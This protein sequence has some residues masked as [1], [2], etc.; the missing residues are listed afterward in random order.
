ME[1]KKKIN[2]KIIIPI[3]VIAIVVVAVIGI[4]VFRNIKETDT[5][6]YK[7]GDTVSTDITEF[8]LNDSQLTIVLSSII[9]ENYGLP[10]EYDARNDTNNI[11]VA[12]T[13]HTLAYM[14][15]TISNIGRGGELNV[16]GS[17][18]SVKY[19]NKFYVGKSNY[20]TRGLIAEKL[21][22]ATGYNK[23]ASNKWERMT[24]VNS[25]LFPNEKA[26]FRYCIDIDKEITNL[27]D[28]YYITFNLP[29][30]EGKTTPF[31]YVIND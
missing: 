12:N 5:R 30:S 15:F 10:K 7:I 21:E 19:D 29:N 25:L 23:V 28:K 1:E 17:I 6:Y 16:N 24:A 22:V 20:P 31:T 14:D 2:F 8:T 11:F 26:S 27:K 9:N 4:V 18:G 3:I 13:G